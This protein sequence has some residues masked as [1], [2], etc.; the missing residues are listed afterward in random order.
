V[1]SLLMK[2]PADTRPQAIVM[3]RDAGMGVADLP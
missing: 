1:S 2:S 3:A